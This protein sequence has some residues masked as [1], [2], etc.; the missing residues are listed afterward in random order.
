[1]TYDEVITELRILAVETACS[2]LGSLSVKLED[3]ATIVRKL[4]DGEVK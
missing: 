3:W 2:G 1:M 4:R